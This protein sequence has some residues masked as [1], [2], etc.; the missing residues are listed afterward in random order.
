MQEIVVHFSH[1]LFYKCKSQRP[2]DENY[3]APLFNKATIF[4]DQLIARKLISLAEEETMPAISITGDPA[5]TDAEV[6]KIEVKEFGAKKVF[7]GNLVT[8]GV[9]QAPTHK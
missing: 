8:M 4:V 3:D 5:V 1:N 6:V 7:I 9:E 2:H